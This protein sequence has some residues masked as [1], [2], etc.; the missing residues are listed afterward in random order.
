MDNNSNPPKPRRSR[1]AN[2]TTPTNK[3]APKPKIGKPSIG[4]PSGYVETVGLG[5][6]QV[7]TATPTTTYDN[8]N[9]QPE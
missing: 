7:I 4:K 8:S 3:Y 6:L 9:V 2:P 5:K 1:K